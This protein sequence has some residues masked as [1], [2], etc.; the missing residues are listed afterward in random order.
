VLVRCRR[1]RVAQ[2]GHAIFS[3]LFG[4]EFEKSGGNLLCVAAAPDGLS[5]MLL[6]GSVSQ[7]L[8]IPIWFHCL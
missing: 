4:F 7:F 8:F 1:A 6:L 5:G 2:L 3:L